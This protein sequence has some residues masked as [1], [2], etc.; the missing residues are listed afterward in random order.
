MFNSLVAKEE[1]ECQT[2]EW[3]NLWGHQHWD[4]QCYRKR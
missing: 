1:R 2:G 3:L 4:S